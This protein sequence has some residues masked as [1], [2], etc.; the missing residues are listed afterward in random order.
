MFEAAGGL[1]NAMCDAQR[2]ERAGAARKMI[3][4]GRFFL[5][6]RA[7]LGGAH[8]DWCVDDWDVIAAEVAAE[9]GIS[10]GR[11]SRLMHYGQVL[12]EYLPKLAD[13]FKA[14]LID[15]R[16][17]RIV[18][19]R[20]GLLTD[21]QAIA[22]IDEML[23]YKAPGWNTLSDARLAQLVDWMVLDLDPTHCG[24]LNSATTTATWM[25]RPITLAWPRS[26]AGCVPPL[27][28][29]STRSSMSWRRRCVRMTRAPRGNVAQTP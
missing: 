9:L 19:F 28:R 26:G 8:D 10:R 18:E 4:A 13:L 16:L 1:L 24:W 11:A 23:A 2:D 15:F 20:T 12:I 5:Q 6:R 3:A 29:R 25:S 27:R 7:E 21:A 17:I 14:G 22:A